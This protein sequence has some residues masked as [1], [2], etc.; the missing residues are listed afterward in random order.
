MNVIIDYGVGNILSVRQGFMRAG[1]ETVLSKDFKVISESSVLILPGVGAFKD[2]IDALASTGLIPLIK[3]HVASGKVLLGICLGMQLLF[4]E[5]HEDGIHQGLGLLK[6][7]VKK[8]PDTLKVPHMGW[9]SLEIDDE[10]HPLVTKDLSDE[11]VYFVHSYY[12]EADLKDL[13]A[14]VSYGV[15]SLAIVAHGPGDRHAVSAPP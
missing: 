13:V 4:D 3:A 10:S 14:S 8:L 2:A 9:N 15:V 5:S 11:Y 12:A 6:G 1:I 7:T